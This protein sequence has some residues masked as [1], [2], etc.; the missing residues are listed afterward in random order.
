VEAAQLKTLADLMASPEE[1]VELIGGDIVRRPMTRARHGRA[2]RRISRDLGLFDDGPSPGGWWI[3]IEISVAYDAHDCPSHDLAGWRR[4]R[5]PRLP[6]GPIDLPPDWVCEIVS[7]GH[8]KKD[9]RTIPLLLRR[10]RVPHYWVIWPED[11]TLVAYALQDGEWCT[12][13]TLNDAERGRVPPF[14]AVELDL[15]AVLAVD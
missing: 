2:Q 11:R 14:E 12:I 5:L 1:R 8:E 3:L 4:E 10:H 9:T 7:P 13:A 6:D 15:G